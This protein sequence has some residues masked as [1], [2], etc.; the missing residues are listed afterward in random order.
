VGS[1]T[2]IWKLTKFLNV[3][4][5]SW[6]VILKKENKKPRILGQNGSRE[7]IIQIFDKCSLHQNNFFSSKN[8]MGK[9]ENTSKCDA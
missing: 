2:L 6:L 3:F 8:G 5:H 7:S 1:C 9:K 4:K